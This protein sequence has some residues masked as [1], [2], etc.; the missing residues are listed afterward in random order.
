MSFGGIG[1]AFGSFFGGSDLEDRFNEAIQ[2][3][4]KFQQTATTSLEGF[5]KKGQTA[6]D[7]GMAE[8]TSPTMA[9]DVAALRA[10]LV[11]QVSAGLSPFAQLQ[12]EDANRFLENRAITTGNLRSGAIGLQRAELG[13]RVVADEFGRALQT[14]GSIQ[15]RDIASAGMFLQ[16]GLGYA[17]AEN[18]ALSSVGTAVSNVAGA[19]IGKGAVQ[20]QRAAALGYGIGGAF[21]LGA[22]GLTSYYTGGTV[23]S[24]MQSLGSTGSSSSG[25]DWT[26]SDWSSQV[27]V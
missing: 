18:T 22:Q 20:Q 1:A 26:G 8:L 11:T 17:G 2:E 15:N 7:R 19:I 16:T 21:D 24:L 6:F 4:Q 12:M 14:L 27:R 25:A 23:N 10:M 5:R 13:R 3:L 9:P